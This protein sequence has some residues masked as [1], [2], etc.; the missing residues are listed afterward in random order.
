VRGERAELGGGPQPRRVRHLAPQRGLDVLRRAG[1]QR[2]VEEP[3]R[4]GDHA[5]VHRGQVAGDRQGHAHHPALGRGVGRLPDLAVERGHRRG[6]DDHPALLPDR[7]VRQHPLGREPQHVECADQVDLDDAR[8]VGQ[9]ER[10]GLPDG[11][12]RVAGAGAVDRHAERAEA[13]GDVQRG[14]HVGLAA[15]VGGREAHRVAELRGPL[16]P[17]G[18]R[19]VQDHHL[20]ARCDQR[21]R[22]GEP[23]PGRAS[24]DQRDAVGDVHSAYPSST[25][26]QL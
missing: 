2:G 24:R 13:V 11:A 9:R 4:D 15:H 20:R 22:R 5:D 18:A 7:V 17:R 1:Q 3:R 14:G 16:L 10:A 19:Q 21:L 25:T 26:S 12:R 6:V 23:E 8:E